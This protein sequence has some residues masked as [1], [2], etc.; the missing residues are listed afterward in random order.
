MN[1]NKV[2]V[3][4]LLWRVLAEALG[5][6]NA[7]IV[8]PAINNAESISDCNG[9]IMLVHKLPHG[10][11]PRRSNV[12]EVDVGA[13]EEM[14]RIPASIWLYFRLINRSFPASDSE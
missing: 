2:Y 13:F 7:F 4:L 12:W 14:L 1:A 10:C 11:Y 8:W 6:H 3:L 5:V 9:D